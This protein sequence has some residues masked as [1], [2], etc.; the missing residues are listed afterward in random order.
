M[1][2]LRQALDL[3]APVVARAREPVQKEKGRFGRIFGSGNDV[4]IRCA[5][6][7]LEGFGLVGELLESHGEGL[8][9]QRKVRHATDIW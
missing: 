2:E 8:I 3:V 9:Q 1:A 5:I 4:G 6:R 7:G